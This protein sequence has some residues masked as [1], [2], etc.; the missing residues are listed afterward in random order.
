MNEVV[1][2]AGM[3]LVT[4]A[5]RYPLLVLLGRIPRPEPIFRALAQVPAGAPERT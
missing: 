3:A 1:I 2:I 5:V 4:L